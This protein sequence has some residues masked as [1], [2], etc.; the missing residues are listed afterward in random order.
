MNHEHQQTYAGLLSDGRGC[1][2]AYFAAYEAGETPMGADNDSAIGRAALN[3]LRH[4]AD[5][6]NYAYSYADCA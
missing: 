6:A 4:R 2:A 1:E 5:G 3:G